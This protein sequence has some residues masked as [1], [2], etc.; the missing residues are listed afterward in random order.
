MSMSLSSSCVVLF[1]TSQHNFLRNTFNLQTSKALSV[2]VFR[3]SSRLRFRFIFR[4][5]S[6][7]PFIQSPG[8]EEEKKETG[9]AVA[10]KRISPGEILR[11]SRPIVF[12]E[13]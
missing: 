11:L 1:R 2:L 10:A 3:F 4:P 8:D 7:F 5:S 9:A 12:S 6:F 13:T